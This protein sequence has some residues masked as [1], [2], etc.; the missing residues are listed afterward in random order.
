MT[1]TIIAD[2]DTTEAITRDLRRLF[3]VTAE[4]D[5]PDA[6]GIRR[7][8]TVNLAERNQSGQIPKLG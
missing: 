3:V 7:R 6:A 4:A 8:L 2:H 5:R 1:I